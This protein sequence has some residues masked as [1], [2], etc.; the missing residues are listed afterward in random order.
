MNISTRLTR[1]LN[2]KSIPYQE[3][4]HFHSN[5]SIGTAITAN[6]SL[7]QIAKAVLLKNHEDK[8]LMAILPAADKINLSVLNENLHGSY[9]LMKEHEV[10]QLF[11]DCNLGAVPPA[12]EAYHLSMV[13]AQELTQ[14]KKVYLEAG[15]HET[16]LCVNQ[17][18]FKTLMTSGKHLHFSREVFH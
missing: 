16:L 6:I 5:S 4:E 18:D 10:Y 17:D 14:L 2:E 9:Q 11:S 7:K 15:D 1:Y 12:A 3:V 8:K 13:C